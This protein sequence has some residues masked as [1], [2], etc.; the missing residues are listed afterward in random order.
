MSTH[1]ERAWAERCSR[2]VL[3]MALLSSRITKKEVCTVEFHVPMMGGESPNGPDLRFRAQMQAATCPELVQT[4]REKTGL[5]SIDMSTH[6]I[7]TVSLD[8]YWLPFWEDIAESNSMSYIERK[9]ENMALSQPDALYLPELLEMICGS[10]LDTCH[11]YAH[12]MMGD[13]Q[14]VMDIKRHQ[15]KKSE[16]KQ[17]DLD[18]LIRAD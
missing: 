13:V 14:K 5:E 9:I 16:R 8:D 2:Y 11:A 4:F 6:W 18:Q 1:Y 12:G 15:A 17:Y 10:D 3:F 7:E